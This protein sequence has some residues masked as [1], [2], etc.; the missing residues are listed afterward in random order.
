MVA[1]THP[2]SDG[3]HSSPASV[4]HYQTRDYA[5]NNPQLS[6]KHNAPTDRQNMMSDAINTSIPLLFENMMKTYL[7]PIDS[8]GFDEAYPADKIQ[9]IHEKLDEALK[10]PP[11]NKPDSRRKEKRLSDAWLTV[12]VAETLCPGYQLNISENHPDPTDP[13]GLKIDGAMISTVFKDAIQKNRPNYSLNDLTIEMKCGGTENDA[14]DDR[15]NKNMES[16]AEKRFKVRGQLMSYG[17]RHLYFQHRTALFMLFINGGE[18]RVIRWDRSGCIVTE[19]LNYVETPEHTKKLLQFLYAYSQAMPEERGID[20]TATRLSKDS[21]GWQ[22]MQKLA[23]AHPKDLDYADGTVLDSVPEGFVIKAT[24]DADDS[25][26]FSSNVLSDDPTATTGFADFSSLGDTSALVTPVFKYVRELFRK[27]IAE[28]T[29]TCYSLRVCGRDYLVGKPTFAPHG[30]V[31]R[32]TR[33]YVALEWKTQ[34]FVFLKDAWR[35]FYEGVD[36]EGA[37]LEIL[38]H[39]HIP[40]VPTLVCHEDVGGGNQE[41]HASEY[42]A[43]GSQKPDVFGAQGKEDRPIAPLPSRSKAS[44]S[45]STTS[46]GSTPTVPTSDGQNPFDDASDFEQS[47]GPGTGGRSGKRSRSQTKDPVELQ[48]GTGLRHLTHYRIVVAQVCLP[49]LVFTSGKQLIRVLWNCIDAHGEVVERCNILHRDVSAGNILILP[50]VKVVPSKRKGHKFLVAW[51][52]GTWYYMS[53]YSVQYPGSLT[54]VA[55]ELESFLHVFLYLAVR[56]LRSSLPSPGIFV[57]EYF[58]AERADEKG[59]TLCGELKQNVVRSGQLVFNWKPVTFLPD[60]ESDPLNHL[61]VDLLSHFKAHYAVMEYNAA[62][63]LGIQPKPL[64]SLYTVTTSA[65]AANGDDSDSDSDVDVDNEDV[66]LELRQDW[67]EEMAPNAALPEGADKFDTSSAAALEVREPTD[68][69][70]SKAARLATHE[71]VKN[72]FFKYIKAN[73][74]WPSRDHVGDQLK[75]Y[76]RAEQTLKRLR[77]ESTMVAIPEA[78]E[79]HA[80][81]SSS[82]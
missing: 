12:D 75:D 15:A 40:F 34:R 41:T 62:Q 32:G 54:T 81:P 38:N 4:R 18:F 30:M 74:L 80:Q 53:V 10:P 42:S 17:E 52:G 39:A 66:L 1:H 57:D 67:D 19:A 31:G 5:R 3:V 69:E 61:I 65:Y 63:K 55:D 72:L 82:A 14:W 58:M 22:W 7:P 71:Y 46:G 64:K 59:K 6:V 29:W 79:S 9:R 45:R 35:P 49:S 68:E 73:V 27:S 44:R 21:C 33:G 23:A 78:E 37:T 60:P 11:A 47:S 8:D 51:S 76:V 77:Y 70:K 2:Q 20:T 25:S 56:F 43:T 24:R 50:I 28:P 36:P 48:D 16:M 13:K 26:L